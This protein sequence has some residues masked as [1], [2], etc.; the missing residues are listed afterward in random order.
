V[1]VKRCEAQFPDIADLRGQIFVASAFGK[2]I[3]IKINAHL[4]ETPVVVWML[5]DGYIVEE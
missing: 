5:R 2:H 3:L 1:L 4:A